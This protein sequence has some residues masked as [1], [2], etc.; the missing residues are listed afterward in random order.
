MEG[1]ME[2]S[3]K[4]CRILVLWNNKEEQEKKRIL[5]DVIVSLQCQEALKWR[6]DE[7]LHFHSKD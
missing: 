3:A 1:K 2:N 7:T 5:D 6:H 4:L